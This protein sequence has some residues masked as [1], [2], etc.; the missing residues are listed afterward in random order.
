MVFLANKMTPLR[1]LFWTLLLL[2]LPLSPVLAAPPIRCVH[3]TTVIK[4]G[5]AIT[6]LILTTAKPGEA[7]TAQNTADVVYPGPGRPR[8]FWPLSYQEGFE[9]V[10]NKDYTIA[11]VHFDY[12]S[13][14]P[15]SNC[16][17]YLFLSTEKQGLVVVPD[18]GACVSRFMAMT[19]V[20]HNDGTHSPLK[21]LYSEHLYVE[22][23][24][25]RTLDIRIGAGEITEGTLYLRV[26]EDGQLTLLNYE[27]E[28]E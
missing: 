28:G 12:S 6:H 5:K 10:T 17:I 1:P 20:R 11:A 4:D 26:A 16:P 22:A 3:Q 24:R 19:P 25:G 7:Q 18:F 8:P 23:M 13:R 9:V 14:Q 15:S 21:W 2:C 27:E